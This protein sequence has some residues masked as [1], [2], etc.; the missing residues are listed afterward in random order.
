MTI[1]TATANAPAMVYLFFRLPADGSS[2]GSYGSP[3]S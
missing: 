3:D 1:A 2:S